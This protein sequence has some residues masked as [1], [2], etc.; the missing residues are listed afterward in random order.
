MGK[1]V[2]ALIYDFDKTL[3]TSDMQN[4]KFIP[5]LFKKALERLRT[6]IY[7]FNN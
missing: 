1:P 7:F 2:V 6:A 5:N 3:A 4:F